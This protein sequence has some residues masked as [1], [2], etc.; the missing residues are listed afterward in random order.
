[1][2]CGRAVAI[3]RDVAAAVDAA[4]RRQ[5]VHGDLKPE[6]ISLVSHG[7]REVAKV[8][9]FGLAKFLA[10]DETGLRTSNPTGGAL[11]G[12]LPYMAPE[13]LRGEDPNPSW[14]L[15]ALAVIAFE[16]LNG[17]HPFATV[18]RVDAREPSIDGRSTTAAGLCP[19][20]FADALAVD[21][22]VRPVSAAALFANLERS[23]RA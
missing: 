7:S 11:L 12:T 14:D 18:G 21:R 16:M 23:L 9:D 20:F 3:L 5:I 2:A 15:W 13:Q 19:Q 22:A 6:N 8:L 1:M 10:A 17:A 4:H